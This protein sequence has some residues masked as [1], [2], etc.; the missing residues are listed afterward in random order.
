MGFTL[1]ARGS[2]CERVNQGSDVVRS[3]LFKVRYMISPIG[4]GTLENESINN[5][6][7]GTIGVNGQN[8]KDGHSFK[9]WGKDWR[10]ERMEADVGHC[11]DL[12][13]R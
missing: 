8:R 13:G 12:G 5:N 9:M 11:R 2:H 6:H 1:R 10:G 4:M 3:I 7:A